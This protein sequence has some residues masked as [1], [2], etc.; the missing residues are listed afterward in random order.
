VLQGFHGS[1]AFYARAQI[2]PLRQKATEIC[3]TMKQLLDQFRALT[4]EKSGL[5][6]DIPR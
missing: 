5:T 4:D 1:F 6:I 2:P 3:E